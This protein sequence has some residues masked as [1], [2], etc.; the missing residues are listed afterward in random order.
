M[1][2]K[3]RGGEDIMQNLQGAKDH[4]R[5]HQKYPATKAELVAECNSLSDYSAEDKKEFMDKLP[6]GTYNSTDEVM[7]ALGWPMSM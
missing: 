2:L 3:K 1:Y 7:K 6:E 5:T 4:L